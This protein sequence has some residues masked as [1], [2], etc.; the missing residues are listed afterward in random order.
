MAVVQSKQSLK[1]PIT[2]SEVT[3][4]EPYLICGKGFI[5]KCL[6]EEKKIRTAINRVKFQMFTWMAY[7]YLDRYQISHFSP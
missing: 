3:K 4:I 2:L 1:E 7:A 5:I 6:R